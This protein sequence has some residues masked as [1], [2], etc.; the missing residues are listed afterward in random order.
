MS[1]VLSHPLPPGPMNWNFWIVNII[2][3]FVFLGFTLWAFRRLPMTY[4]LYTCVMVLMPLFTN[5]IN[6]ITRCYLV[7]F[8]A[9]LLLAL[10][11]TRGTRSGYSYCIMTIFAMLQ[12]VFMIFFVLGLPIMA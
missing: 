10:W 8:P 9:F 12:A 5:S 6:S 2:V 11:T 4:A 7:V 1:S 3:I